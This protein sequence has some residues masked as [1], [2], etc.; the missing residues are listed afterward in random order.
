MAD[1]VRAVPR[2]GVVFEDRVDEGF[3]VLGRLSPCRELLGVNHITEAKFPHGPLNP[4]VLRSR[5]YGMVG[6]VHV[7]SKIL[8]SFARSSGGIGMG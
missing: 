7:R 4:P 8:P 2:Q 3:E 6:S 5:D 1:A